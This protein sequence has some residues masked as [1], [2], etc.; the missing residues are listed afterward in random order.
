MKKLK[1]KKHIKEK[2]VWFLYFMVVSAFFLMLFNE[3]E[4]HNKNNAQN[5]CEGAIIE[6]Y[7]S[8][9]DKYYKCEVK[10]AK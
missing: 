10:S 1:L 9:G 3:I 5:R 8:T 2:I 4:Q 7:T 6:L